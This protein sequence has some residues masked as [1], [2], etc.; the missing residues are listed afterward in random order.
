VVER[1]RQGLQALVP[2]RAS[3]DAQLRLRAA[4]LDQPGDT[5]AVRAAFEQAMAAFEAAAPAVGDRPVAVRQA[6]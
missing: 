4:L 2:L 1:E 3:F 6:W 5:A